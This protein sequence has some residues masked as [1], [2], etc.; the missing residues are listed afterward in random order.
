MS[1]RLT[2]VQRENRRVTLTCWFTLSRCDYPV[3]AENPVM[4]V[5][6]VFQWTELH[7]WLRGD[8]SLGHCQYP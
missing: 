5:D 3:R 8:L 1:Q 6:L 4:A 2:P 7:V